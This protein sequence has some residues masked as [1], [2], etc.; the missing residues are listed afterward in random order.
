M[1]FVGIDIAS[2]THVVAVVDA[3]GHVLVKATPFKEESAGYAKLFELLGEPKDVLVA[4]EATGHYWRELVRSPGS[5]RLRGRA[6]QSAAHQPLCGRGASAHQDRRDR[7]PRHR[8]LRSAEAPRRDAAA[9]L[10]HRGAA[11]VGPPPR[12]LA[13]GLR[14]PRPTAASPRRP[15]LPGIHAVRAHARQPAGER[16]SARLPDGPS[17]PRGVSVKRLAKLRGTTAVTRSATSSP[18]PCSARQSA[19]AARTMARPTACRSRYACED[20]DTLRRAAPTARGR[21]RPH[22]RDARGRARC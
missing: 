21:H 14:R 5:A 19:R 20:L 16:H 12:P 6:A 10:G 18:R 11:R 15:R 8:P 1:R 22:S 13:P 4:M 3:E 7:R 9:R 17:V 2:E